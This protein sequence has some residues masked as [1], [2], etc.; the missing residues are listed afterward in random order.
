MTRWPVPPSAATLSHPHGFVKSPNVQLHLGAIF[1][2]A[3][4]DHSKRKG[5]AWAPFRYS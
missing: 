2:R 1:V 5:A 4:E 3:A